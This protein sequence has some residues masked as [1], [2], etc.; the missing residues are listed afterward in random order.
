MNRPR[1]R[2]RSSPKASATM[3][4]AEGMKTAAASAW[5]TLS[6]SD[7]DTDTVRQTA[8]ERG[9]G[10]QTG[11][12]YEH[13]FAA[14]LVGEPPS[15]GHTDD[16]SELIGVVMVQLV[17]LIW[18]R[19]ACRKTGRPV[20]TM[21]MST[22]LMKRAIE[23]MA[24]MTHFELVAVL[25]GESPPATE[26]RRRHSTVTTTWTTLPELTL[27][28]AHSVQCR[29]RNGQRSRAQSPR[30]EEAPITITPLCATWAI[31]CS[32]VP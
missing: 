6:Q 3:P 14:E 31:V 30:A 28:H 13:P 1:A 32:A 5:K 29:H 2:L 24:K 7:Q 10:E 20:A 26:V 9:E 11:R 19:R 16:Q 27:G 18:V 21:L 25:R 4:L 22:E 23:T 17:Q 15:D 8:Q 12:R